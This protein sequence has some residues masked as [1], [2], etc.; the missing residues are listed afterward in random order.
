MIIGVSGKIG[1]G[2]DTV[3]KIIQYVSTNTEGDFNFSN[4]NKELISSLSEWQ[5][6]RYADKLKDIV[7]LLIGCTREQ[8]E[9]REFKE[10]P[11]GEEWHVWEVIYTPT[12]ASRLFSSEQERDVY[13]ENRS[14][15]R[16]KDCILTDYRITPRKLMQLLGTEAGREIIH[17]Q[18]WVNA[19]FA[20]YEKKFDSD[21]FNKIAIEEGLIDGK[22][23]GNI[24]AL[25]KLD[26][27]HGDI[28]SQIPTKYKTR[29]PNW[30]IPDT[31]FPNEAKAIKDRG[32]ILIRVERTP[33]ADEVLDD[34]WIVEP[35]KVDKIY[36]AKNEGLLEEGIP[37]FNTR[38][39]A[40]N[41]LNTFRHPSETSLDD[42]N[43]WDYVI[44]NNGTIENLVN[45]VKQIYKK[46][47]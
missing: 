17:P 18:I 19:L 4:V 32:G 43:Q 28:N 24:H 38:E 12:N 30:I 11:L 47:F 33:R 41:Y 7:C 34:A 21:D 9:D 6:K 16:Q 37:S 23:E 26:V 20:D 10:S 15:Q 40:E 31:R 27:S 39:D 45:S 3:A 42:Y 22:S 8:L 14:F 29:Y 44:D 5:I 35:D 25:K 13:F 36:Q 2:K 46:E 1:S